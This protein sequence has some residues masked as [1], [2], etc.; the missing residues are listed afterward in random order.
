MT[1][2]LDTLQEF[3]MAISRSLNQVDNMKFKFSF[4]FMRDAFS[5]SNRSFLK[6]KSN[7]GELLI[8]C[9]IELAVQSKTWTDF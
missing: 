6:N 8:L 9:G 7:K 2:L 4:I 3:R 1:R 5:Y